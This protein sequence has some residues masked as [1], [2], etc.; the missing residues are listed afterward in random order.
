[1]MRPVVALA[2]SSLLTRQPITSAET[3]NNLL[4]SHAK[5]HPDACAFGHLR[6]GQMSDIL[7]YGALNDRVHSIGAGL[8]S[9]GLNHGERVILL[10]PSSFDFIASFLACQLVGAIPI[11][12][13]PPQRDDSTIRRIM[14]DC[15]A[16]WVL[17]SPGVHNR[18][19][20][21]FEG[22]SL[23]PNRLVLLDVDFGDDAG[24][25]SPT[26]HEIALLQYTSGSTS[27]PKGVVLT[28][29]NLLANVRAIT[30]H[31][32]AAFGETAVSWLPMYHDMGLIGMVLGSLYSGVALHFMAPPEFVRNPVQWLQAIATTGA[33]Y[34]GGPNFAYQY[35]VDR[36]GPA[37]I[38][39][40]DLSGWRVA[41]NGA[42]P[43]KSSVLEAFCEK[44]AAFGFNR[45]AFLPCYG[46]AESS[47][48]VTG[49]SVSDHPAVRYVDR[50]AMKQG[51]VVFKTRGAAGIQPFVSCGGVIPS[52]DLV[53]ADPATEERLLE[54]HCG[55]IWVSGPSV[56][57]GY[58]AAD[59]S[60][61][62]GLGEPFAF[63][64]DADGNVRRYLRTGDLGF[65]SDDQLFVTGRIKDLIILRGLNY[66][67]QDLEEAAWR[68]HSAIEPNGVIALQAEA[69]DSADI[70]V[71][72]EIRRE[73]V[74]RLDP[75]EIVAAVRT[76]FS[77]EFQLV[78][79]AVGLVG[80]RALPRT[81][82]GKVQRSRA[83]EMHR[84]KQFSCL[85]FD[86]QSN[87]PLVELAFL[88][89]DADV[90]ARPRSETENWLV[91][92]VARSLKID[93]D[94][95]QCD[96]PI[97]EMGIDSLSQ[98]QLTHEISARFGFELEVEH[99]FDGVSIRGVGELIGN[100][101]VT[102]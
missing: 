45:K 80:P 13:Y 26:P 2:N 20:S 100:A 19:V 9:I 40:L 54:N 31:M 95:V 28:H 76:A 64:T 86:D 102:A 35:C 78:G 91:E 77:S 97:I 63:L 33:S 55:E 18:I 50:A 60:E 59:A 3:I 82:S 96:T 70:I 56:T 24:A 5:D 44:F 4:S 98:L 10:F 51:R 68:S 22:L 32:G 17:A 6:H 37:E 65:V 21:R 14:I 30:H 72:A 15:G 52:H 99:Y 66:H 36:I 94:L 27:A 46:L 79:I 47:L 42:E 38:D 84:N 69:S 7:S 83:N 1:M 89:A 75:A 25:F 16:T 71:F 61:E 43:I 73:M 8:K 67:P 62:A 58:W 101:G 41:T 85:A 39:K 93:R 90:A 23:P 12:A 49:V 92:L 48:M 81:S 11:P 53:I 57:S 87:A 34:S 74:A 88:S 29:A